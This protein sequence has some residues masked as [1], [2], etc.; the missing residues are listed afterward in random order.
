MT[1]RGGKRRGRPPKTNCDSPK[2]FQMHLLKKPKY[3]QHKGFESQFSTPSASRA[4][5]P[6]E[7]ED[8]SRKSFSRPSTSSGKKNT[9]GRGCRGRGGHSGHTSS[10]TSYNKRGE[11]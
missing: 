2:K 4:S 7:S 11:I 6:Q 8:S 10:N 1:G 9:R 5:S 3:L